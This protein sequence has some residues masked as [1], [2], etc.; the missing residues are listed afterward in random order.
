MQIQKLRSHK[1]THLCFVRHRTEGQTH[2][3]EC[4]RLSLLSLSLAVLYQAFSPSVMSNPTSHQPKSQVQQSSTQNCFIVF[5]T[6]WHLPVI[7]STGSR[8]RKR[9]N[10]RPAS[11][12][13]RVSSRLASVTERV[14]VSNEQLHFGL[15]TEMAMF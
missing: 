10:S 8:G 5:G 3:T 11:I 1:V 15:Y 4:H 2:G 9:R 13:N 14:L 12:S 7:Q 6:G